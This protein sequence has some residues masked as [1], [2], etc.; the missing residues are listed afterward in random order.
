MVSKS[1][2]TYTSYFPP[3][4]N[5]NL[6]VGDSVKEGTVKFYLSALIFL[7]TLTARPPALFCPSALILSMNT[8]S[9]PLCLSI[10]S[11]TSV[12]RPSSS[13][14]PAV[15]VIST[16]HSLVLSVIDI[17]HHIYTATVSIKRH[18][19][20]ITLFHIVTFS[21][22]QTTISLHSAYS[23]TLRTELRFLH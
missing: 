4:S 12:P 13:H 8:G 1:I 6:S 9:S 14:F 21:D 22:S 7:H 5:G 20:F 11:L 15:R 23:Y 3:Q 17:R 2:T 10:I 19:Y 16:S 18:I